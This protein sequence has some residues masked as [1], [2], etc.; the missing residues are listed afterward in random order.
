MMG[1]FNPDSQQ[2]PQCAAK[3]CAASL[4]REAA[5]MRDDIVTCVEARTDVQGRVDELHAD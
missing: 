1:P 4:G 3:S 5:C 2:P